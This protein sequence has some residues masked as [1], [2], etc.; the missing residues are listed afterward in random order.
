M[1]C[2]RLRRVFGHYW[3]AD[4]DI[5]GLP[6]PVVSGTLLSLGP[7][8]KIGDLTRVWNNAAAQDVK[9]LPVC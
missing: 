8:L 4:G 5:G 7:L 1:S 3:G 6:G 2:A 9:G